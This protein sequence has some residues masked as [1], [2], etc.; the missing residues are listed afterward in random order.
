M[1][2]LYHPNTQISLAGSNWVESSLIFVKNEL[3]RVQTLFLQTLVFTDSI[4][5]NLKNTLNLLLH[6][7]TTKHIGTANQTLNNLTHLLSPSQTPSLNPLLSLE[8]I[9]TQGAKIS[10]VLDVC[11]SAYYA[12]V[13]YVVN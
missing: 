3:D 13:N 5:M 12:V 11:I 10:E 9:N 2:S 8:V 1:V 6:Y 4:L 7:L